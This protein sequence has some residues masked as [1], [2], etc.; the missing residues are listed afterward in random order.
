MCLQGFRAAAEQ[1][2]DAGKRKDKTVDLESLRK[3]ALII[4]NQYLSEKVSC[5]TRFDTLENFCI[6][7]ELQHDKTCFMA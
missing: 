1:Q 5:A 2:I 7:Y 6:E 4:F 3:A